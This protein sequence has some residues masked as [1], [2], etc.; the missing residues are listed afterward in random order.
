MGELAG[1]YGL[2]ADPDSIPRL[3]QEYGLRHPMLEANA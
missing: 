2:D 1:R 3:C